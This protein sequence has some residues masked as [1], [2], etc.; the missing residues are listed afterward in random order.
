M[1]TV[2]LALG[3]NVGDAA[4]HIKQAIALLTTS[5]DNLKVAPLYRSK[6]VGYTGQADFLNTAVS[7][8]TDLAPAALLARVKDIE[9]QIG[10]TPTFRH[11]PREIDIDIIL[12][13]D[14]QLQTDQLT[15]PHVSFRERDF[16]LRPLDD[17]NP[18]LADPVSGQTV[19]KLLAGLPA[20]RRSIIAQVD[21][22]S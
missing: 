4:G 10:R 22:A 2:Y 12:Y 14:K 15:I 3:S 5:L 18:A 7:G 17:L 16:V 19:H 21:A 1:I 8:R 13:G 20:D 11:G 6:A 9:A